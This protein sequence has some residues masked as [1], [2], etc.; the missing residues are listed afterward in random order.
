MGMEHIKNGKIL[1]AFKYDP[2]FPMCYQ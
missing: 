1:Y 2:V